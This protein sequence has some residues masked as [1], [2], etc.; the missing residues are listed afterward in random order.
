MIRSVSSSILSASIGVA[1]LGRARICDPRMRGR[2]APSRAR[3]A[4]RSRG[5]PSASVPSR[6]N[7]ASRPSSSTSSCARRHSPAIAAAFLRAAF[8]AVLGR[9]LVKMVLAT[10]WRTRHT[11]SRGSGQ[12]LATA[13]AFGLKAASAATGEPRYMHRNPSRPLSPH[14]THLAMGAAHAGL[15]P[16][17][18][19]RRR[20]RD[21]RRAAL[22]VWWLVAAASG[23]EAYDD[24][25]RLGDA[26]TGR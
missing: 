8:A 25:R 17:P 1:T 7:S 20:A 9:E 22:L 11:R 4:T 21:R 12:P 2:P 18:G 5:S 23:A 6:S 15:D 26:G 3:S 14:L 16:A 10:G 13:R 24:L 19:H